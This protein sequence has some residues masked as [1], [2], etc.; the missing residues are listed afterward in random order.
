MLSFLG[1]MSCEK[2]QLNKETITAE[3]NATA[4]IAFEDL[5]LA[6]DDNAEFITDTAS[7][8][9]TDST[10]AACP[11]VSWDPEWV[12]LINFFKFPKTITIDFG[13]GCEG[14]DGKIRKGIVRGTYSNWPWIAGAR[15][16]IVPDA[17]F[18]D[19]YGIEGQKTITYRGENASGNR[20]WDIDVTNGEVTT[21]EGNLLTWESNRNNELIEGAN[22]FDVWNNVYL[23]TGSA[24]GTNRSG[25]NYDAIIKEGLRI[26]IGCNYI[27]SGILELTPEDLKTRSIDYGDGACDNDATV[28]IGNASFNIKL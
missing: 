1:F 22:D 9:T 7:V 16:D 27:T 26:E 4:E 14:R 13:T 2:A 8:D 6:I 5:S 21:P 12:G 17:Y 24:E 3:D 15:L 23:I 18:V 28:A 11:T 10:A 19:D 20:N 25:R